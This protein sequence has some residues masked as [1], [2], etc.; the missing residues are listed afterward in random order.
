M[1]VIKLQA[2]EDEYRKRIEEIRA[3][4]LALFKKYVSLGVFKP[5]LCQ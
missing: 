2:W 1:K 3:R 5:C 4:E